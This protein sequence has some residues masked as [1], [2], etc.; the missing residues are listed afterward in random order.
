MGK[1][2][3]QVIIKQPTGCVNAYPYI[4]HSFSICLLLLCAPR[5]PSFSLAVCL[6]VHYACILTVIPC[7]PTAP[8]QYPSHRSCS[9]RRS[10]HSHQEARGAQGK[11]GAAM[12]TKLIRSHRWQRSPV[13]ANTEDH[14]RQHQGSPWLQIHNNVQY[15]ARPLRT[16]FN[17]SYLTATL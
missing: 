14:L 1:V 6:Y 7:A 17:C 13:R 8:H 4:C 11:Q 3:T 16:L 5:S 2:M 10:A 9:A 15:H 12:W